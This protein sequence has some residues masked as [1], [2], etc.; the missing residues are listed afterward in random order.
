MAVAA[1]PSVPIDGAHSSNWAPLRLA[2]FDSYVNVDVNV[3]FFISN[4]NE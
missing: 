3:L 1:M 4:F 2:S